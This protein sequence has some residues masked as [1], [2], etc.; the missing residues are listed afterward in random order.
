MWSF[1]DNT[2]WF[3]SSTA[4]KQPNNAVT[5]GVLSSAPAPAPADCHNNV[6]I[7]YTDGS[8]SSE[9]VS[10]V[11]DADVA[12]VAIA[13]TS[14]EGSDRSDLAFD[15]GADALV[16]LTVANQANTVVVGTTPGAVLTPWRHNVR[17]ILLNFMPGQELGNAMADGKGRGGRPWLFS[18]Q[19]SF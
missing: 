6:C 5:S 7:Y 16:N 2:C 9:V 15:D 18:P 19:F 12:I 8:N 3:K 10:L 14:S 17:A 11:K 13:T 4:G 1:S